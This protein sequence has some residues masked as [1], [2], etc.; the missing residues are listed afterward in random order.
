VY[1]ETP[2]LGPHS[3]GPEKLAQ[4]ARPNCDVFPATAV[5]ASSLDSGADS[6]ISPTRG[7]SSGRLESSPAASILFAASP[8]HYSLVP[9]AL[10]CSYILSCCLS[11]TAGRTPVHILHLHIS[12]RAV[13]G[14]PRQIRIF[15]TNHTR[16]SP[17]M[18]GFIADILT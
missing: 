15:R 2:S 11:R 4:N 7:A 6:P 3:P 18:F 16:D 14:R 9:E 1:S 17:I 12:S 10:S 5:A 8:T 13:Q